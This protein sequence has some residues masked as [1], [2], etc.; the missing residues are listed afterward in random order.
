MNPDIQLIETDLSDPMHQKDM[1]YLLSS[2]ALDIMGGGGDLPEEVK[3]RLIPELRKNP[4]SVI[5]L[6]YEGQTAVGLSICF[7]GFS[8][9]YAKPLLNLH[10]FVVVKSHRGKGIAKLMLDKLEEIARSKGCCKLTLEVLEGNIR[11]Q[12]IYEAFGFSAYQLDTA[13]GKAL[14]WDKKLF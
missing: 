13:M 6:A 11:A 3:H 14:F 9:F 1:L 12:K 4:G 7:L 8:T 5:V 10:D 2:Y